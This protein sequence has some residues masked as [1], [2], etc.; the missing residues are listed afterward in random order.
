MNNSIL[1]KINQIREKLNNFN[2]KY[3][4][5]AESEVSDYEYDLLLHELIQLE[6][7]HPELITPNSP[8]QRVGSDLTKN[9]NSVEHKVPMLSLTNTYSEEELRAFD[10]RV[11][12]G[13]EGER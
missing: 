5:L 4:V 13:L 2:Y 3:Y 7:E 10:L 9:F 1:K 8:S 11:K 12:S 6:S